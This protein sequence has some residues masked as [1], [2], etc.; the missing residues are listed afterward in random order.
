[1]LPWHSSLFSAVTRLT[2][3]AREKGLSL[4]VSDDFEGLLE[5]AR[6][7][8]QRAPIAPA[9]DPR[10]CELGPE[11]GFWILGTDRDG[12]VSHLQAVRL[13]ETGERTLKQHLD[14]NLLEFAPPETRLHLPLSGCEAA[15]AARFRGRLCYHGELWLRGGQDGFRGRS[16]S[17]P[18]TRLGIVLAYLRWAPEVVFALVSSWSIE[19]AMT[20]AYGYINAEPRG[21]VWSIVG[22]MGTMEEWLVWVT[23]EQL[24]ALLETDERDDL[25]WR[26]AA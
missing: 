5:A 17:G 15:S 6:L 22:R 1:M 21:A 20:D 12:R 16:L 7:A 25:P 4:T 23:G 13:I 8:P 26:S 10:V 2:G 14:T 9:F 24:N 18:L 19:K 11:N 3:Q